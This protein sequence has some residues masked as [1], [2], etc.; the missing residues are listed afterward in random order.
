[1]FYVPK[2]FSKRT[3][4]TLARLIPK[5]FSCFKISKKKKQTACQIHVLELLLRLRNQIPPKGTHAQRYYGYY[6]SK[7][8]GQRKKKETPIA[9]QEAKRKKV[10]N[11]AWAVMIRQVFEV[12][13][14]RCVNCGGNMKLIAFIQA[15]QQEMIH[16]ILDTRSIRI[17]DLQER[18]RGPP[19][20]C[21][22]QQAHQF[23]QAHPDAYP[24]ENLDQTSHIK[25][26]E[27][28]INPP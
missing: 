14:L 12:D 10:Q 18:T 15:Q 11:N 1:M 8:R 13:P 28:F 21:T 23:V 7:A 20:W 22:I 9:V 24:E 25:E 26:E 6:S 5:T 17:P 2:D 3:S 4:S 16:A 27:Y 19:R